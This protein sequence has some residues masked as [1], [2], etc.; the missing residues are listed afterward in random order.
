MTKL[1]FNVTVP[2]ELVILFNSCQFFSSCIRT[3][4][5]PKPSNPVTGSYGQKTD[6]ADLGNQPA[7]MLFILS[8]APG[9]H[10]WDFQFNNWFQFHSPHLQTH[11]SGPVILF[12]LSS[13]LLIFKMSPATISSHTVETKYD[14]VLTEMLRLAASAQSL[15]IHCLIG[16]MYRDTISLM[17]TSP[18]FPLLLFSAP[19]NYLIN[20]WL[21]LPFTTVFFNLLH[22]TVHI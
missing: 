1:Q 13:G 4:T 10:D 19:Q 9:S 15:P 17:N 8:P 3:H 11:N 5:N 20:K 22:I 18:Y 21:F 16:F 2:L 14:Y 12:F 7:Y 6:F